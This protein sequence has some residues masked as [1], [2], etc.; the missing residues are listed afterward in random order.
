M[1][2]VLYLHGVGTT[3]DDHIYRTLDLNKFKVFNPTLSLDIDEEVSRLNDL[4]KKENIDIVLSYSF[5]V[6]YVSRMQLDNVKL[7]L[8]NPLIPTTD[9]FKKR[10]T[11]L[12]LPDFS[13]KPIK[14]RTIDKDFV[15]AV[16]EAGVH[17]FTTVYAAEAT[18]I[19]SL[20]DQMFNFKEYFK[21]TTFSIHYNDGD[22][23]IINAD[24]NNI[25]E[26]V[27]VK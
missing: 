10:G 19:L 27:Y 21:D 4:V 5:G 1:I 20:N 3:S 8:L 14:F 25:M 2:K 6:T 23:N 16:K 7:V 12:K 24:I 26:S 18:Y 22:H 15:A 11:V 13:K 17:F 9:F